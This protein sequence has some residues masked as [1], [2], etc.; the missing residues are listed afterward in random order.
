M[1]ATAPAAPTTTAPTSPLSSTVSDRFVNWLRRRRLTTPGLLRTGMLLACLPVAFFALSVHVAVSRNDATVRTVGRDATGGIT[2]AQDIKLNLSELDA[3]VAEDLLRA[4]APGPNGFPDDYNAKRS[5][6]EATLV[7]AAS[8]AQS[9]AAF[10]Q[11]LANIH[12]AVAHY[13]AL[14]KDSFAAIGRHDAKQASALY[15]QA[16]LVMDGT[17]LPQADGFDK[18]NTYVLNNTYDQH[19]TDSRVSRQVI[20]VAWIAL[21]AFVGAL[22]LL[23]TLKFRRLVNVGLAAGTL[24]VAVSGIYAVTKL[25]SSSRDL[26]VAREHAFDSVHELARARATVVSARQAEADLLLDPANTTAAQADFNA[27]ANKVFRLAGGAQ[28]EAVARSGSVPDDAG[29]YL[30]TVVAAHVSTE[31]DEAATQA[32]TLFGRYL[33]ANVDLR[34]LVAS[35]DLAGARA[36][37][38]SR[39]AFAPLTE[40]LDK[41]Q[42]IDQQVFD[43]NAKAAADVT[44]HVDPFT[45]VAAG[46]VVALTILG[47]YQRL[48]EYRG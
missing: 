36:T 32:L 20:V 35:G 23:L 29:G 27:Q 21:L 15:D 7:Q 10:S 6:L 34:A 47:L 9:G 26:T 13:H 38:Q 31:G 43:R 22:Q 1:T 39:Q 4:V 2:A 28:Q 3:V 42:T 14:V 33:R 24:L 12:Y 5:E 44:R 37:F 18:A 19:K 48:G 8:K 30:A 25:H 17:L 45:A 16:H 41:T 40:A 11:P 46:A